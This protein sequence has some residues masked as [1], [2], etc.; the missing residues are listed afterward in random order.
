VEAEIVKYKSQ[1]AWEIKYR[2]AEYYGL[3][4]G[5]M[6]VYVDLNSLKVVDLITCK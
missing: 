2:F 5:D 3:G 4:E 1:S 6:T